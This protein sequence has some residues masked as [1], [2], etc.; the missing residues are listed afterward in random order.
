[1]GMKNIQLDNKINKETILDILDKFKYSDEN[2]EIYDIFYPSPSDPGAYICYSKYD[3]VNDAF[4]MTL[5]NHGWSGGIYLIKTDVV[6][7]QLLHLAQTQDSFV[8]EVDN[9]SFFS[10]YAKEST[11]KNE[12]MNHKLYEMHK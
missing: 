7:E 12:A 5:G 2:F 10:H 3:E 11:E 1:M 6:V 8:L 4:S 9:A